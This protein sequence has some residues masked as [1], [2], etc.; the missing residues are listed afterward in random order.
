MNN[1]IKLKGLTIVG[2]L[3]QTTKKFYKLRSNWVK[4]LEKTEVVKRFKNITS[5]SKAMLKS[6]LLEFKLMKAKAIKGYSWRKSCLIASAKRLIK[7]FKLSL[8]Y[9]IKQLIY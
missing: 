1:L 9:N 7:E 6:C 8:P 5:Q 3:N 4:S 2:Y